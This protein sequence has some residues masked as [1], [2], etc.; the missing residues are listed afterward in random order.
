MTVM[1]SGVD[2]DSD[3]EGVSEMTVDCCRSSMGYCGCKL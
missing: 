1:V 2:V 3:S